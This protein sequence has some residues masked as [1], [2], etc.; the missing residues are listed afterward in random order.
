MPKN[1]VTTSFV[2][3][4]SQF[5]EN[6]QAAK[7]TI[8]AANAE[9]KNASASMD[10][11]GKSSDGVT[12]QIDAQR[13]KLAAQNEVLENMRN[14]Y[15]LVTK[16]QGEDSEA[17]K[18]LSVAI[19]NQ[20]TQVLK[21]Q[22]ALSKFENDLENVSKAEKM[23]AENG[24]TVDQNLKAL[25]QS[26]KKAEAEAV[27]LASGLDDVSDSAKNAGE[28]ASKSG[29]GF[30]ILKGVVAN[31]ATEAVKMAVDGLKN[32]GA[33]IVN[34]AKAA[35][36]YADD[37]NTMATV[38][39]VSTEK[40]QEMR[41]MADLVD[42][43]VETITGS[44][45]K[46]EKTMYSAA[47]GNE[48]AIKLFKDLKV[49]VT[50]ANGDLRDNEDVFAEV[51]GKLGEM[52]NETERDAVAMSILGKSAKDLNPLIAAGADEIKNL[53]DE[54]HQMGYV[55]SD[56]AL[57]GLNALNDTLDRLNAVT[58]GVKNQIGAMV[59]PILNGFLSPLL[60][61]FAKIPEAAESGGISGV[62]GVFTN[63]VQSILL[64]L[65]EN[66]PAIAAAGAELLISVANGILTNLPLLLSVATT[67]ILTFATDIGQALPD[68]IPTIVDVM[69]QIVDV[70]IDNVDLLVD[71]A[72][73]IILGL[74]DGLIAALPRL[75]EKAPIIIEK[76]IKAIIEVLPTLV[77]AAIQIIQTLTQFL[78]EP[79][80]LSQLLTATMEIINTVIHELIINAPMLISAAIELMSVLAAGL[81][82]NASFV[83]EKVPELI[84]EFVSAFDGRQ[85]MQDLH[86]AGWKIIDDVA[87]GIADTIIIAKKWGEDLIKN[88]ID[89]IKGKWAEL[90]GNAKNTAEIIKQFLGFSEPEEGPLSNFHTFAPDMMNLFIKGINDNKPKLAEAVSGVAG[91][92]KTAMQP[93][94]SDLGNFAVNA[95]V[96][97]GAGVG[98]A[99]NVVNNYNYTQ[100]ITSPKAVSQL[101]T[102]RQTKNLLS[103]TRGALA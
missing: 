40:L 43:S 9:L 5:K 31:L 35:A 67:L 85:V 55:L 66:A 94:L 90:K 101:E 89:G 81:I 7:K 22:K 16:E 58:E 37:I 28:N 27:K 26:E 13:K 65:Q 11:F 23:A 78:M 42:V 52:E 34:T 54:A 20:E 15:A 21:T 91:A 100:N 76:L 1:D 71:A 45:T 6:I 51:I 57:D 36:A 80:I 46:L 25:E 96:A 47:N 83:V 87:K 48:A 2:A 97:G 49:S 29:D 99:K 56:E 95:N 3:D 60:E 92:I 33:E 38:T 70:L 30:T 50:D 53:S 59:A 32:L 39:G 17:A 98:G 75:L 61:Q 64:T 12:A 77:T 44:M 4:M 19:T 62:V 102:Y 14:E 72:I 10:I 79:D 41:Y 68:L 24:L 74:A 82:A 73:A 69:L 84:K 103:L 18:R 63:M 8:Q 88:F 93:Q 86:D